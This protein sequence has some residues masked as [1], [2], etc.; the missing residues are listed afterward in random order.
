MSCGVSMTM[1]PSAVVRRV[2]SP[3]TNGTDTGVPLTCEGT[4]DGRLYI[5]EPALTLTVLPEMRMFS[6][7]M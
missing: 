7:L 1:K 3:V 5:S 6:S 4:G 2:I